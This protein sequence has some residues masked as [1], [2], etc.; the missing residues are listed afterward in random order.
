MS[1]LLP[2]TMNGNDSGIIII[3]FDKKDDFQLAKFS[4]VYGLVISYTNKQQSAPR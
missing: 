2:T 4:N 1:T 3:P